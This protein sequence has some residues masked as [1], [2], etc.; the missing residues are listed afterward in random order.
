MQQVEGVAQSHSS[1]HG[2]AVTTLSSRPGN[3]SRWLRDRQGL[4][5][6][7]MRSWVWDLLSAVEYSGRLMEI[8]IWS[9]ERHIRSS[10]SRLQ[11]L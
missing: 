1:S 4:G 10:P 9:L 5:L 8:A 2:L 11:R 3:W 6:G 7:E